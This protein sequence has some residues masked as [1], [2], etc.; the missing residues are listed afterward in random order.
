MKDSS[1]E[2]VE[3]YEADGVAGYRERVSILWRNMT[4]LTG[5][6]IAGQCDLR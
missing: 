3:R 1:I 2:S 6:Q 5:L 4:N